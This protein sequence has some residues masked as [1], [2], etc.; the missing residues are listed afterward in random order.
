[1]PIATLSFN[2]PEEKT[3]YD[4]ANSAGKMYSILWEIDQDIRAVLKYGHKF[5]SVDEYAEHI[6]DMIPY[7]LFEEM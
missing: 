4:M 5:K 2:L 7:E 6:R 3:D 1:M